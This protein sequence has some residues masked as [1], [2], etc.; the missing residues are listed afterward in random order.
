M[1]DKW[2]QAF[3]Y[4]VKLRSFTDAA[5]YLNVGQPTISTHVGNLEKHFGVQLLHRQ[6]RRIQLTPE[7]ENLFAITSDIYGHQQEAIDYLRSLKTLSA[8]ELKFCAV[9]PYDVMELLV[10]LREKWPGIKC[11][12]QLRS[13]ENVINDLKQ[14][15]SDIGIVSRE[16]E[17]TEIHSVF[18]RRHRVFVVVN[19]EHRLA[20]REQI[21]LADLDGE[22]MVVRTARST[23]QAAFD[24]AARE[25]GISINPVFEMDSRE[26]V[27][28]AVIRNMG[29]GVI[30]ETVFAPHE[31]I[32]PLAVD[33]AEIYS[34]AYIVCL[35]SRKNRP[36][37][38]DFLR[39]AQGL[40]E[41][42]ED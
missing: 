14:F 17:D 35:A 18:Y 39:L 42:R 7:G 40:I 2:L 24:Q 10:A 3:H 41:E 11:S 21:N 27:R 38:K 15:R 20:G 8:G 1:Y 5:A 23:T 26:G 22:D 25:A 16:F 13:S 34:R 28:E 32:R 9:R 30:S 33:D 36:L 19:R 4:V 12:V 29:I 6:K 31:D 37:I